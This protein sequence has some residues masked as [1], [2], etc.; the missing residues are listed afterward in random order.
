MIL[1]MNGL[2]LGC[3]LGVLKMSI[4]TPFTT[5]SFDKRERR[6]KTGTEARRATQ[7]TE[8]EVQNH[9]LRG[10]LTETRL[11]CVDG[12]PACQYWI[13]GIQ[14]YVHDTYPDKNI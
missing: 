8:D 2:L 3:P 12:T 11:A 6:Q 10:A 4:S 7:N 9:M 1:S 5:L 14:R 13:A